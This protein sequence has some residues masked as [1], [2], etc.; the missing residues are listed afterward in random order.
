MERT[1]S[2]PGSSE[3]GLP[4]AAEWKLI[5]SLGHYC[6]WASLSEL[7]LCLLCSYQG[8]EWSHCGLQVLNHILYQSWAMT[9]LI[10]VKRGLQTATKLLP[11]SSEVPSFKAGHAPS[12]PCP[13]GIKASLGGDLEEKPL[14]LVRDPYVQAQESQRPI[15]SSLLPIITLH[16]RP[17]PPAITPTLANTM[18]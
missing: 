3:P 10:E 5:L 16:P 2:R 15:F 6:S 13:S 11:R 12:M 7:P 17:N 18:P 9:Q 1:K 4:L 8:E 14:L